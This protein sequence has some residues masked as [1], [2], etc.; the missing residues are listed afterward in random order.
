MKNKTISV[1]EKNET[2]DVTC[3]YAP[4]FIQVARQLG[5]KFGAGVWVF[6]LRRS[7]AVRAA[8][9]DV[10]GTDGHQGGETVYLCVKLD[11][12]KRTDEIRIA[13]VTWIRKAGR[14]DTPQVTPP[15]AIVKGRL[16]ERG[17]STKYPEITFE[18]GTV[19]EVPIPSEIARK[20]VSE[21]PDTYSISS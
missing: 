9:M 16:L 17:G 10:F 19:L 3:P 1:V 6:P 8:L 21:Y 2:V 13:G 18:V 20:L 5:G 7:D 11:A 4:E 14:D 12:L 15:A